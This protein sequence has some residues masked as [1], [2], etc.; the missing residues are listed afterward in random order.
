[1]IR[2]LGNKMEIAGS[3]WSPEVTDDVVS[4][5][6][7]APAEQDSNYSGCVSVQS[8]FLSVDTVLVML[9]L[10]VFFS[11]HSQNNYFC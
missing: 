8:T 2:M 10:E 6:C 7:N 9:V 1:M 11:T 5:G 3:I 4:A